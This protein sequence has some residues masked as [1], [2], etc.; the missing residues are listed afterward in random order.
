VARARGVVGRGARA[1]AARVIF[2]E[3]GDAV[4]RI[5]VGQCLLVSD[6]SYEADSTYQAQLA[7]LAENAALF[8]MRDPISAARVGAPA[9]GPPP[10]DAA[11][12]RPALLARLGS[13]PRRFADRPRAC[14]FFFHR[15]SGGL[16]AKLAAARAARRY[17]EGRPLYLRW[18]PTRE[19]PPWLRLAANPSEVV[20]P[21]RLDDAL[22]LLAGLS[23]VVTD[24]YHLALV[25]WSLGVPAI[26][27]GAGAQRFTHSVHD[28]KKELFYLAQRIERFYLF[29]EDGYREASRLSRAMFEEIERADPGPRVAQRIRGQAERV[30]SALDAALA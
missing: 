6:A 23:C 8:A 12:L 16:A 27:I 15:T 18:L 10:L 13:G 22:E 3:A 30:L 21:E 11:L 4:R 2:G 14:G 9:S 29:A 26:C 20:L 5:V 25:S 28:K 19:L 1:H 17:S 24:T 7:R